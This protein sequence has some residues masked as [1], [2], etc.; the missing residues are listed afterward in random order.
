MPEHRTVA[1]TIAAL[2]LLAWACQPGVPAFDV[3]VEGGTIHDGSGGDPFVADVGIRGDTITAIGDLEGAGSTDRIDATGLAVAPGFINVLSWAA[4][5]LRIDGRS[6]SDIRQGVT[7]EVFGEGRSLGPLNEAMKDEIEERQL[8]DHPYPVDWTTLDEG[9]ERLVAGGIAPNVASFVGATTVRIHELGYEDRAPTEAELERMRE[10]VRQAMEEGALGLGTSLIYAPAFYASTRE[11]VE[12]ARVAAEYDGMYISHIR[13]E[14]NQFLEALDEF[15]DVAR[16]AGSRAEVYHFKAKGEANRPKL[17]L[18]I[19]RI[20]QARAEG[21]QVSANMYT[22]AASSTGLNATLPPW[23]QEGGLEAWIERM[24][25]PAVRQ[26]LH[27]EVAG[28]A[29][30]WTNNL[31]LAGGP[32]GVLLVGFRSDELKRYTGWTLA[33]VAA[34]LGLEPYDAIM[35]LV[36]RD[37]SRVQAVYFAMNEADLAK[38]A[39]LPWMTFGSDGGSM[40]PEG[41][42]LESQPH[43][44]AYGNFARVLGM[45]VRDQEA[46]S[47]AEAVRKMTSMPAENLRL[48]RRGTL[49]EGFFADVVVFDPETITDHATFQQPHQ[50]ATGVQHVLVNGVP[51][52]R[53]GEHT[54]ATPGRVVRGPGFRPATGGEHE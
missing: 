54:G 23:V 19:E 29:V 44:R 43:P 7:L 46:L 12:L 24:Q 10:L 20:E 1:G 32:E 34:D 39:A 9:L 41:V 30:G 35:D 31:T 42:F 26:R 4:E 51:V 40:A 33:E 13:D 16:H 52:L 22:Y 25:D 53:D 37:G 3:I 49:E 17:D 27:E 45:L 11:L 2:S 47:L 36:V 38:K 15:L 18:A 48:D 5:T 50:Y 21:L 14:G 6:Q 28:P 8:E